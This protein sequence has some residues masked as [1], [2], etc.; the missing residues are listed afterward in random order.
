MHRDLESLFPRMAHHLHSVV[1]FD[2]IATLLYDPAR[3]LMHVH[4]ME[5]SIPNGDAMPTEM[6][7]DE[8][9]GG[10]VWKNQQPMIIKDT[11]TTTLFKEALTKAYR[12]GVRSVCVLPLTTA[13][14]RLGSLAFGSAKPDARFEERCCKERARGTSGSYPS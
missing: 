13:N 14:R 1:D 11:A 12:S 8:A 2:G 5:L 9:P 4:M 3:D 10:W 6:K 7:V